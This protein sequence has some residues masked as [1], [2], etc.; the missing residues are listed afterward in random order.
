MQGMDHQEGEDVM[1]VLK[2]PVTPT[3]E[4]PGVQKIGEGGENATGTETPEGTE[5]KVTIKEGEE[6]PA[7][8]SDIVS[9]FGERARAAPPTQR[10]GPFAS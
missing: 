4:K 10:D 2:D 5:T 8:P 7:G 6:P 1:D 9:R 3:E